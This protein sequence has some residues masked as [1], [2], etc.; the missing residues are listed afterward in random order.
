MPSDPFV[1]ALDPLRSLTFALP[2][3]ANIAAGLVLFIVILMIFRFT[4][5]EKIAGSLQDGLNYG[6]DDLRKHGHATRIRLMTG[7]IHTV[8]M[9]ALSQSSLSHMGTSAGRGAWLY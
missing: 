9:E 7:R 2:V 1:G 4:V 6:P 5:D 3:N 8:S